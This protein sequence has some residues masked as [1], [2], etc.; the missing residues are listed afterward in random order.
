MSDK[1]FIVACSHGEYDDYV[2]VDLRAFLNQSDAQTFQTFCE[3]CLLEY[4]ELEERQRKEFKGKNYKERLA[5]VERLL[6]EKD[7]TI[8]SIRDKLELPD[9]WPHPDDSFD[10]SELELR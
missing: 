2:S 7:E 8:K 10:I 4:K 3:L 1:V 5:I 9:Y 6:K